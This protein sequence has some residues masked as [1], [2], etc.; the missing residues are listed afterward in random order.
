[1]TLLELYIAIV[2]QGITKANAMVTWELIDD[3]HIRLWISEEEDKHA[4]ELGEIS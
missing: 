4:I 3:T 2:N 1:M